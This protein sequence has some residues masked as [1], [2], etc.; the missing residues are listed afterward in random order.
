MPPRR[1]GGTLKVVLGT[2]VRRRFSNNSTGQALDSGPDRNLICN[3]P[4]RYLVTMLD[5]F[6][7]ITTSG[8]VLWSRQGSSSGAGQAV[9]SLIN[10]IFIAGPF[11]PS[12][13]A[14]SNAAYK[15]DK[16]TLKYALVQDLGLMFVV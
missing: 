9:N 14:A 6:E 1:P 4:G 16:Y 5:A 11:R 13:D 8:V 2:Y 3:H 15:H 12:K 7:V 10:D